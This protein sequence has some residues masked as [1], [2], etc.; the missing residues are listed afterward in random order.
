MEH[1]DIPALIRM[2]EDTRQRTLELVEDLTDEQL[3]GPRLDIVNPLL[4]EIGHLAWFQERWALRE[5]R[6]EAPLLE[7]GDALYDSSTVPHDTRW[8]LSLPSRAQTLEYMR[9]VL[10]SIV[11]QLGRGG[12]REPDERERYFHLL[13]IL[14]EDMHDEAFTYTRQTLAYSAPPF[15]ARGPRQE[16]DLPPGDRP[17]QRTAGKSRDR[18]GATSEADFREATGSEGTREVSAGGDAWHEGGRFMLGSPRGAPFIFDNEKWEHEVEVAPFAMARAPVTQEQFREFVEDGG[19]RRPEL[20]SPGGREWLRSA[21]P[22]HPLYWQKESD[23]WM[24]RIFDRVVPLHEQLPVLHVNWFEADAYCRWAGRRLPSEAEWEWSA[25]SVGGETPGVASR[26]GKRIYPWG[27][28][29]PNPRRANL[30]GA[31]GGLLPVHDLPAG[32][33]AA[34]CR[35][36]I[37]NIWEWTG[38]DFLPYPG[39]EPDPYRDYSQP[40]FGTCKV[41]RGGCWVTRSRLIRSACRDF[42]TPDRRDVWAGFR[43]C[44]VGPGGQPA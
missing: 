15:C 27:D 30:D 36:L 7:Q 39:F 12:R 13:V 43:T 17:R 26:S 3:I 19:Y 21:S 4:W 35:Q 25:S 34:G 38:T 16:E 1:P 18:D 23:L 9:R 20:W 37:G 14:H 2:L 29:P 28:E 32:D 31:T 24:Q 10:D 40:W 41:L 44:A 11:E 5:L 33:S 22:R 42:Y 6:G 8:E